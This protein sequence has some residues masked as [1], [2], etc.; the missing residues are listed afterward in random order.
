MGIP[1]IDNLNACFD[2]VDALNAALKSDVRHRLREDYKRF[3]PFT[4]RNTHYAMTR[5]RVF[6]A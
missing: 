4:G 6:P 2:S 5:T 1:A 3:P